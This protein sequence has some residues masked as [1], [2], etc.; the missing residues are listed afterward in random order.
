MTK[1]I[2]VVKPE[3]VTATTLSDES[4]FGSCIDEYS[5]VPK[6]FGAVKAMGEGRILLAKQGR[7]VAG[8]L[9]HG[10]FL[11]DNRATFI[12]F[13]SVHPAHRRQG[14]ATELMKHAYL[15][16][17][18]CQDAR[19]TEGIYSSAPV[20]NEPAKAMHEKLGYEAVGEL[21]IAEDNYR[22]IQYFH[23]F[24]VIPGLIT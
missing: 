14:V 11:W 3:I 6:L 4:I 24:N 23:P 12:Q 20:K 22:E 15:F 5:R 16:A 21:Y 18:D 8:Y 13:V 19:E 1:S 10:F 2:E 9:I 7:E 17:Y